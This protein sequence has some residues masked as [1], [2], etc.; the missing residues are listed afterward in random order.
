LSGNPE[1]SDKIQGQLP[2][3]M[4]LN[5]F[6]RNYWWNAIGVPIDTSDFCRIINTKMEI[7]A[8][9]ASVFIGISLGMIKS[10]LLL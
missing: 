6:F 3:G 8:Y 9:I 10:M 5:L 7:I 1:L 4:A 2:T